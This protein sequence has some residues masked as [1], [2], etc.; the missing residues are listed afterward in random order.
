[1]LRPRGAND[2]QI[3]R[4]QMIRIQRAQAGQHHALGQIP[5]RAEQDQL[6]R[7]KGHDHPFVVRSH[8]MLHCSRKTM[9]ICRMMAICAAGS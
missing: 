5:G 6:V 9:Q 4:H 7:N 3:A 2:L 8:V 1:M